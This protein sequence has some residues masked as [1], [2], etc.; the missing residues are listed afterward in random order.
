MTTP[1][2][3]N[4]FDMNVFLVP[5]DW[6]MLRLNYTREQRERE[7]FENFDPRTQETF[8]STNIHVLSSGESKA[9][10]K[11]RRKTHRDISAN[12]FTDFPLPVTFFFAFLPFF[13]D[14]VVLDAV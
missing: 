13:E 6:N 12:F 14:S 1:G 11:A 4:I 10:V 2:T 3:E 8:P 9:I 5:K 7:R